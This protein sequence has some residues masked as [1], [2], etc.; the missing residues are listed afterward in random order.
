VMSA[1]LISY[2]QG[3]WSVHLAPSW[4]IALWTLFA[5]QLNVAYGWLKTRLKLAALFGAIAG[6]L[7]F[8][9]GVSLHAV[10]FEHGWLTVAVLAAGWACLLPTVVMLARRWD[11]IGAD[12]QPMMPDAT[13]ILPARRS[14]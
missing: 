13:P 2:P 1:G 12:P 10:R 7:S 11:G 14:S 5:A 4:I 6:P 3:S 9:A 8:R